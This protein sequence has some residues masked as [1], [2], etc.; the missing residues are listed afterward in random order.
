MHINH[1]RDLKRIAHALSRLR[2]RMQVGGTR[3]RLQAEGAAVLAEAE[4]Q[5]GVLRAIK[6]SVEAEYGHVFE[7]WHSRRPETSRPY[8]F[9]YETVGARWMCTGAYALIALEVLLV[10]WL[11]KMFLGLPEWAAASVGVVVTLLRALGATGVRAYVIARHAET[12]IEARDVFMRWI[13]LA[14]GIE[15]VLAILLLYVRGS[16]NPV[17]GQ[18]TIAFG[19]IST[20]MTLNTMWLAGAMLACAELY[21]FSSR[22]AALWERANLL[23]G[24]LAAIE[25]ITQWRLDWLCNNGGF[26]AD[27][28]EAASPRMLPVIARG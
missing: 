7:R 26:T 15:G 16:T 4:R 3:E 24:E 22:M 17:P 19:A 5:R 6:E 9:H 23:E 8:A 11:A 27:G 1:R 20:L 25:R 2:R 28:L 18:V 21:S 12:P 10:A 14:A 13:V